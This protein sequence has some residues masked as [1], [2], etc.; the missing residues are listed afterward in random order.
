MNKW[1]YNV[2]A[3]LFFVFS[4]LCAVYM[5]ISNPTQVRPGMEA[6]SEERAVVRSFCLDDQ[7]GVE[8]I[9]NNSQLTEDQFAWRFPT[10][11]WWQSRMSRDFHS[12]TDLDCTENLKWQSVWKE[13]VFKTLKGRSENLP[14]VFGDSRDILIMFLPVSESDFLTA[15]SFERSDIS[16]LDF[17]KQICENLSDRRIIHVFSTRDRYR[18]YDVDT[19]RSIILEMYVEPRE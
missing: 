12:K 19:V 17:R 15:L 5:I 6:S 4:C 7:L 11:E 2:C 14:I 18:S 10:K 3:W 13:Y 8:R 9:P 16:T 1:S